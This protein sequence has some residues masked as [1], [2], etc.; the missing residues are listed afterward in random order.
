MS[1]S[2]E[3][4]QHTL[5]ARVAELRTRL[6]DA[7]DKQVNIDRFLALVCKYTDVQ[8]LTSE[9]LRE[10]NSWRRF[11]CTRRSGLM[12]RRCSGCKSFTTALGRSRCNREDRKKA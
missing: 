12:G 7:Q 11:M 5:E 3:T 10:F 4:E 9:V 6:A 1:A 8:E 2:Y